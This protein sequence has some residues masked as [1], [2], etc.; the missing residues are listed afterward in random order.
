MYTGFNLSWMCGAV[1]AFLDFARSRRR[2]NAG[3]VC[4]QFY[5]HAFLSLHWD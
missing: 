5:E 3:H 4:S 2:E 1:Y